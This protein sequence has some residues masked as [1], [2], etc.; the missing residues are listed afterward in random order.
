MFPRQ[1][2]L[3]FQLRLPSL[4]F[5]GVACIFQDAAV[6]RPKFQWIIDACERAGTETA[7]YRTAGALL[8]FPDDWVPP[9]VSPAF[10]RF[11]L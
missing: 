9:N 11:K 7:P 3:Y 8:P 6:S 1:L 4:Y 10:A 5:S 2:Y